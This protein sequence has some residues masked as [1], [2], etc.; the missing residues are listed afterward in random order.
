MRPNVV[1]VV[2]MEA[3]PGGD[4]PQVEI[5]D[6]TLWSGADMRSAVLAGAVTSGFLCGL[7]GLAFGFYLG[8]RE[9]RR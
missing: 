7:A 6:E 1:H 5:L 3:K 2:R 4:Q 8:L 9:G